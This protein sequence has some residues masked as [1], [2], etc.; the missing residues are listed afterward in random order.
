MNDVLVR[1]YNVGFGDAFLVRLPTDEGEASALFDCGSHASSPR[2]RPIDEVVG[3]IID[4]VRDADG[5][6]RIDV[7]V[8]THRHQDHVSGFDDDRWSE[9]VVGEVWL[10]WTEDPDDPQAT[11]IRE[12]QSA[13]ARRLAAALAAAGDAPELLELA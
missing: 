4:D 6:P 13:T 5:T 10:P 8:G 12:R 1:M 2:H 9:V 11:R 3:Q 7:V